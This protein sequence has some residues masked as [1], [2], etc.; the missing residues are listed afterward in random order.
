[1]ISGSDVENNL[2]ERL[3]SKSKEA[4]IMA[5]EVFN[6]PTIH[7]RTEAFAIFI[8]NAW[9]LMLKA[10]L[11][12]THGL[13]SIYYSDNDDRSI[14]LNDSMKLVFQ[15]QKD[16]VFLNLQRIIQLRN[17]SVHFFVEEFEVLYQPI[18]QACVYNFENFMR[19]YHNVDLGEIISSNYLAIRSTFVPYSYEEIISKYDTATCAKLFELEKSIYNI[20]D[21]T[22]RNTNYAIT[23]RHEIYITKKPKE[24]DLKIALQQGSDSKAKI[25][26]QVVDPSQKYPLT[27]KKCIDKIK[28]KIAKEKIDVNFGPPKKDKNGNFIDPTFNKYHFGL[29]LNAFGIKENQQLSY[30]N[31]SYDTL[32][33]YFYSNNV[34][35]LIFKEIKADP[36]NII[37]KLKSAKK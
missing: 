11:I 13:Q 20:S 25:I 9:E 29:F 37:E 34:V 24:A 7:Y 28:D 14:S 10:Y 17:T 3:L 36:Q 27:Q 2:Y 8:C 35:E 15:N 22:L 33:T 1:M 6:K 18:F 30:L 12:K 26:K 21:D 19:N 4:Y 31:E 23:L 32:K 5:I 16:P